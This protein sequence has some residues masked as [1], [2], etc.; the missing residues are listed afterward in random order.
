MHM[1]LV[2]IRSLVRTPFEIKDSGTY[3]PIEYD[4][5]NAIISISRCDTK[6]IRKITH[7]VWLWLSV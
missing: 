3:A 1:R 7:D 6:L 4:V 5:F 2:R